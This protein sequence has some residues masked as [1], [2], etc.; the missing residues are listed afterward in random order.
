[1]VQNTTQWLHSIGMN[2]DRAVLVVGIVA[3]LVMLYTLRD[4]L[5]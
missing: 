2:A 4:E 5:K 3:C 1:M